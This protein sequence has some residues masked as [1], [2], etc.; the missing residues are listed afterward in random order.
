MSANIVH[1]AQITGQMIS[2]LRRARWFAL[3]YAGPIPPCGDG[4]R[5]G[6]GMRCVTDI[7]GVALTST[8]AIGQ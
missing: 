8:S 2:L 7:A 3:R 5:L 6:R 1:G 4:A